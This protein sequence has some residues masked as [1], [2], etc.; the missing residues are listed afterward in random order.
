METLRLEHIA[1][2]QE[3]ARCAAEREKKRAAR[4]TPRLTPITDVGNIEMFL[5]NFE[6]H[7]TLYEV[8]PEYWTANLIPLLDTVSMKYQEQMPDA[9]KT[10]FKKVKA[11]LISLHGITPNHYSSRVK[12]GNSVTTLRLTCF[13]D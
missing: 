1:D 10:V 4:D 11:A 9:D 3:E 7:M 5:N 12:N 2:K 8:P 6:S 13:D